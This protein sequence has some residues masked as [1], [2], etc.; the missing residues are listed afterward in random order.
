MFWFRPVLTSQDLLSL[1]FDKDD[2]WWML[3]DVNVLNY[4]LMPIVDPTPFTDKEKE[5]M[6]P[7]LWMQAENPDKKV[8]PEQDILK[9]LIECLQLLCQRRGIREELRKRKVYYIIR[10]MD[11]KT[12]VEEINAAVYEV[13]NLLICD[14]DPSVP[15]DTYQNQSAEET[16]EGTTPG[17]SAAAVEPVMESDL[18]MVD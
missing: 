1:L 15:V 10:N 5:G 11:S 14:E 13:V 4:L 7:L 12:E 8:E 18:E 6:D 9:M 16:A 3:Y 2:H 17:V